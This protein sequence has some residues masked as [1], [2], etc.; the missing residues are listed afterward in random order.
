ML[1]FIN[2]FISLIYPDLCQACGY[3]LLKGE[4]VICIRCQLQLPRTNFHK[5]P[6]NP[7]IKH[8]WGKV[9]VHAATAYYFFNKGEKVQHLIHQLK[10]K[11]AP[12]VG[13]KVGRL[14]GNE[15]KQSEL[16]KNVDVIVPV[17]LHADK[18]RMRGYNQSEQIALGLSEAYEVKS[19][20]L[21]TR[22]KHTETQTRKHRYQR[23]QNVNKVFTV[24]EEQE[25]Y[26]KHV[27]L[28]DDV[29]TTGSTLVACAEELLK[30]EGTKVSV[31]AMAYAAK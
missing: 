1:S 19:A 4:E 3:P 25:V 7:I 14:F 18:L 16:F 6:I 21:V 23:Y 11:N 5:E 27:L 20:N 26:R 22:L 24:S 2:D 9:P 31:A 12:A 13:I 10:Y 17:P 29:I 15:L 8:F 28:V 30:I